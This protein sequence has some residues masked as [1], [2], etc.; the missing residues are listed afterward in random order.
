MEKK[1]LVCYPMP[2]AG[3]NI[4][5]Q[6]FTQQQVDIQSNLRSQ[7][8]LKDI[9]SEYNA[10]IIQSN[11]WIDADILKAATKLEIIALAQVGLEKIDIQAAKDRN[12]KIV[13]SKANVPSTAEFT[14]ALM[15]D[16]ARGITAT[17]KLIQSGC[18]EDLERFKK[19]KQIPGRQV[20]GATLGIIGLG[21]IGFEL[22]QKVK[23]FMKLIPYNR[24]SENARS[25]AKELGCE[26]C[27]DLQYLLKKS[28]F[29]TI[30][31]PKNKTE[32]F[33]NKENLQQMKKTA[34]LI[35][36]SRG[37]IINEAALL[38]ALKNDKDGIA[39]AALDVFEFEENPDLPPQIS[40]DLIN[41]AESNPYKLLLSPHR[42]A[43]TE[44]AQENAAIEVANEICKF[45]CPL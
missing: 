23:G 20:T 17:A 13:N 4:L 31:L 29:V 43:R 9:I 45:L 27:T 39:G 10:V 34:F 21:D 36:T 32:N 3:I 2:D 30:H 28:D 35:N 33:I 24:E 41:F 38:E 40:D 8:D 37:G 11:I 42:G 7:Q 14:M 1:I 5:N 12:I 6:Q 18:F 22:G 16:I 25:N 44:E 15:F 26:L 19:L